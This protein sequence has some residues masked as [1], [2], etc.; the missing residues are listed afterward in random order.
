MNIKNTYHT[1]KTLLSKNRA[2][3]LYIR[4]FLIF[5]C[6]ALLA[7]FI[8]NDNPL[9]CQ[10]KGQWLF[11][12]FSFKHQIQIKTETINYNMGKEWKTLDTDFIIFAPCAYSPNTIDA[13]TLPEKVRLMNKL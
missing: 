3:R 13:I 11:P 5:V 12:A 4:V 2:L 9:V 7:P 10:Y 8:A 6:V 1:Y